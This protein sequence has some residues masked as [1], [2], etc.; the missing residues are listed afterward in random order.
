MIRRVSQQLRRHQLIRVELPTF[1]VDSAAAP[2]LLHFFHL[3]TFP[4]GQCRRPRV[5]ESSPSLAALH[6]HLYPI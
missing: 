6:C 1:P 4:A 3:V 2:L 5:V